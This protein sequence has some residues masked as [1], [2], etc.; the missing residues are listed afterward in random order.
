MRPLRPVRASV[1]LW[2]TELF[3]VVIVVAILVLSASLTTGLRRTLTEEG[4]ASQL[5][6]ASALAS[7]LS[8]QF[9]FTAEGQP[10]LRSQVAAY[11]DIYGDTVLVYAPDGSVIASAGISNVPAD[12]LAQARVQG[13][14]DRPPFTAMSLENNGYVVAGKAIYAPS[15]QRAGSLVVVGDVDGAMAVLDAVRSRLWVTFW[16][17]LIVAGALGFGFSEFIGRR[18]RAMSA[19]AS[20]ISA[21]DFSQRLPMG[22]LPDEIRDLAASYNEMAS[23]LGEAF[24]AVRQREGEIA[25]VVESMAEG[26]I[27]FDSEGTVR[28]INSEAK[29]LL[30]D[31]QIELSG[32]AAKE[33]THDSVVLDAIDAGLAGNA[34]GAVVQLG[35]HTV[36]LHCTPL[37]DAADQADGAVLLLSDVTE[38]KRIEDAQRQFVANASHEM[39]TPIA[40]IKGLLE[41]LEDG[42]KDDPRV[43]DDFIG[44]MQL[45]IDRLG[46]LVA[47]L[48]TLAQLEAGTFE[49]DP[50]PESAEGLL[51]RV[52]GVMRALADRAGVEL[53]VELPEGDLLVMADHDRI[54]QVLLGFADNAL[55]HSARGDRIALRARKRG[56]S[57]VLEVADQGPGIAE[58]DAERIFDRF[59]RAEEDRSSRGAGLG[60]AIAKEIA[61]AHGTSVSVS[62]T[63][64]GGA[65]FGLELPLAE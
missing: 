12:V 28:V 25:A 34:A 63:P 37:R 3:I 39:R 30:G 2:Q 33:I 55:K 59:F 27:A 8:A 45:E 7:Q 56:A 4:K 40:A 46:R 11:H 43:R 52:C 22:L 5:L 49:L 23:K 41:L 51:G 48:L 1:R 53:A 47:D 24:S 64:G 17:A 58:E 42:A 36:L 13:L 60:L 20:A 9:P 14:A 21:G 35:Q 65:T 32:V 57:A 16:V 54:V 50:E 26:V 61:E 19:A 38:Q 10:S 6:N 62:A 29:R 15:G 18:V 44:T 31:P